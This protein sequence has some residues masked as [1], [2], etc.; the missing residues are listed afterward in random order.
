MRIPPVTL[1]IALLSASP[2]AAAEVGKAPFHAASS[3]VERLLDRIINTADKDPDLGP[4]ALKLPSRDRRADSKYSA[5]FSPALERAWSTAEADLVKKDCGGAYQEGE[6]C[7]MDFSPITCA[8]DSNDGKY[9][10]ATTAQDDHSAVIAL[11][12]AGQPDVVATYRLLRHGGA[13]L[14]DGVACQAGPHFNFD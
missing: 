8:Q 6:I 12:W 7:G 10:Y 2:L 1:A 9:Q 14:M 11:R 13:W 4:F 5:L 3:P